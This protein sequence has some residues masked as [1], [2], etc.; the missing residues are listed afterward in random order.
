LTRD[1][2][3]IVLHDDSLLRTT[4]VATRFAGDPRARRGFLAADFDLDEIQTLDAGSWFA[5]PDG[6]PRSAA[7]FGTLESLDESARS[8]YLSGTVRIPSLAEALDW[9]RT[10][11]WHANVELKSFPLADPRRIDRITNVLKS[12]GM[13]GRL[14][15]SSFDH[16]DLL[17]IRRIW[18]DVPLGAL[19][20]TPLADVEHYLKRLGATS[21]HVSR[22]VAGLESLEYR[23]RRHHASLRRDLPVGAG[24]AVFVYTVNDPREAVDLANFGIDGIFTDDPA[25]MLRALNGPQTHAPPSTEMDPSRAAQ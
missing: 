19:V 20:A 10:R 1:G 8:R 21:Y 5:R 4:D 6:G 11:Q 14:R 22:E 12:S 25:S 24:V 9:T 2:V 16:A 15:L 7:W 23:D 13:D 3:P 17:A 18:Q